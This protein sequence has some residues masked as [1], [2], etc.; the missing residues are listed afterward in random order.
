VAAPG[1]FT[2]RAVAGSGE[3]GA[4]ATFGVGDAPESVALGD[5]SGDGI[6]DLVVANEGN[7]TV[8]VLLGAGDGQFGSRHDF[9][10]G[11]GRFRGDRRCECDRWRT[12]R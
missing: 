9:E 2:I 5:V 12:W 8:S 6:P 7:N 1:P 10:T 3:L 4:P 11:W